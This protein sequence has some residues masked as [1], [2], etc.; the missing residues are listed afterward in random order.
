ML[1]RVAVHGA[2]SSS[3]VDMRFGAVV[4]QTTQ[5]RHRSDTTEV[6][7]SAGTYVLIRGAGFGT[8]RAALELNR[9]LGRAAHSDHAAPSDGGA[10]QTRP[11]PQGA[12]R[13]RAHA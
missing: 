10:G 5:L 2:A 13:D 6:N 9:R 12:G 11:E 1:T 8:V 4:R 3:G 7:R